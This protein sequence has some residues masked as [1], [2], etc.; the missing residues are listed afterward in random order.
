MGDWSWQPPPWFEQLAAQVNAIQR[1]IAASV[2]SFV[3]VQERTAE[4]IRPIVERLPEWAEQAHLFAERFQEN[5]RAAYAPNWRH[6]DPK[7]VVGASELMTDHGLNVAWVPR[8]GIVRELL[9]AQEAE[10]RD[11]VLHDREEEIVEDLRNSLTATGH[12]DLAE[13][14]NALPRVSTVRRP[15]LRCTCA[16]AYERCRARLQPSRVGT[17]AVN[18]SVHAD[19]RACLANAHR[20]VVTRA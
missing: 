9:R 12:D 11:Q 8:V 18:R 7:D 19:K 5:L 14:V 17:R 6:L 1:R 15:P 4:R 3:E 20:G 2:E 10:A 16:R 13:S